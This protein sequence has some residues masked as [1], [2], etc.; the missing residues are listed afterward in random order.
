[1]EP[2]T[3]KWLGLIDLTEDNHGEGGSGSIA[4][5]SRVH[6]STT[7]DIID[8]TGDSS[9]SDCSMDDGASDDSDVIVLD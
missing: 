7:A 4:S 9:D 6:V 8:L 3:G 2:V 5:G 1:M